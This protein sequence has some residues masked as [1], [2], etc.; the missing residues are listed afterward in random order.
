M[1]KSVVALISKKKKII[2]FK[3][4]PFTNRKSGPTKV[5]IQQ[6]DTRDSAEYFYIILLDSK[7]CNCIGQGDHTDG[8]HFRRRDF[9]SL[10]PTDRRIFETRELFEIQFV[11]FQ[12]LTRPTCVAVQNF[13]LAPNGED[14]ECVVIVF[15]SEPLKRDISKG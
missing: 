13:W 9:L 11:L 14:K 4:Y 3:S 5:L 12:C 15:Y 2:Y 10:P 6:R 1:H 7:V 8:T